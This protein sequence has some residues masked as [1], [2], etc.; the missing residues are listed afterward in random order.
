MFDTHQFEKKIATSWLGRSYFCFEELDSTNSYLKQMSDDELSHGLLVITNNQS[1]G[2][3]QYERVWHSEPGKN[4]TFSIA[5]KPQSTNRFIVF[6]LAVALAVS[7]LIKSRSG[8]ETKIKWANDVYVEGQKIAGLLTETIY[9]GSELNRLIVGVGLNVNQIS[10]PEELANSAT[11][12]VNII[13]EN[14]ELDELMAD[15]LSRIEYYYRLWIQNDLGL[16]KK[17]NCNLIGFGEWVKLVVDD[18]ILEEKY[19]FLG[20]DETGKL[21]VLNKEL[22][23]NTFSHEQ[24]EIR[25]S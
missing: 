17:I 22:E 4:L 1:K 2:R 16:V 11:S 12:L 18:Q 21:R 3:G 10:F 6:S 9:S 5:L 19:K 15:L 14:V 7:E 24:I 23:V 8:K 25:V 20:I 13:G